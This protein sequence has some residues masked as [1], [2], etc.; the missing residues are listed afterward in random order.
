MKNRLIKEFDN[1]KDEMLSLSKNIHE[2]P[3][4]CFDEYKSSNFIK[5]LLKKHNFIIEEKSGGIDTAFK[6]RFKG[7]EDGPT[8][9]FLAEYDALPEIGHGCGHNLIAAV[10]TGAAIA[11]SK[12]MNETNGEII[13]LG[14]PAEEGGGGKVILLEKGEFDDIDYSLMAHPST[15]ALIGRGGLATTGIELVYRGISAHSAAPEQGINALQ[16]VIQTFN[17]LDSIRAQL[18]NKTNINGIITSGGKASNIIPDYAAC[19]F[20]VR[21]R[22]FE[23]LKIVVCKIKNTIKAVEMLTGAKAEIKVGSVYAERYPNLT[24]GE[25]YKKYMEEQGEKIDYPDPNAKIGSS[26]IGNVTLKMPAIH[27]YFKIV[28][29]Q[30][31]SHSK[32]FTNAS[33]TDKAHESALKTSKAL[34]CTAYEILTDKKLREKIQREFKENV[35]IYESLSLE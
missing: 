21:T 30:I 29:Q 9:A 35:P 27:A 12:V 33:I 19:R 24:I 15:Q 31:A 13:L 18:P 3:E 17:M 28:D 14:T 7:K 16:A 11:L 6:A 23:D 34:A 25:T 4:L 1:I 8:V 26:D 20:S 5:E 2:N 32:D 22:N 10:S